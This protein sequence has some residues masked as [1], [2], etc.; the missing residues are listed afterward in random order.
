MHS[1]YYPQCPY[2]FYILP[3]EILGNV[4]EQFLGSVITISGAH[5]ADVVPKPEVKKAGGVYYTPA[6]IVDYI[7]KNTVG[8]LIEGKTPRQIAN[9][10]ILDPACGSGSFLLGAYTYLLNYLRDWY[11]DNDP[12]KHTKK[13]YQG[14]GAQWYLTN[15]EKKRILLNNIF[16]VDIDSQAVEVTKLSLLLKVLEG[17]D[18]QTL[19]NQYR[20]FHER[21]LPDLGNNIKCGN[22]LIGPDFFENNPPNSIDPEEYRR[23]NPFDYKEEFPHIFK[24]K[25]PGFNA[26]IGNPPYRKERDSK[27][28]ISELRQSSYGKKYYMGKMDFWY[29]FLHRAMDLTKANGYI[30][31]IVPSYWLKSTG[32]SKLI[33][34]IKSECSFLDVVDIGKN[35]VF[36]NVGGQH[37]TFVLAKNTSHQQL[38]YQRYAS[39]GLTPFEIS[40]VLFEKSQ[41]H[42]SLLTLDNSKIYTSDNKIDFERSLHTSLLQKFA[43]SSFFLEGQDKIFLVSQGIV[44]APDIV[45]SAMAKKANKPDLAGCGVFVLSPEEF[46]SYEFNKREK[47]FLK[48]YLRAADVRRYYHQFTGYYVFYIGSVENRHIASNRKLYPNIIRHLNQYKKFITSSNAPYGIHRTRKSFYFTSEKL[49]CP[50]MFDKPCFTYC[51][52]ESYVNFAFNVVVPN[53]PLYSLKYL[54]A[55]LNSSLGAFWFNINGKK[56]GVN[57]DVGVAVMRRFPVHSVDFSNPTEKAKHDKMVKLVD[58]MLDLHKRLADAKVPAEKT[59][60]QRQINTTDKQIDK[61]TYELYDLTDEE[62]KIAEETM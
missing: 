16:G 20:L 32:S 7:V 11:V 26:V 41:A 24:T 23:I 55:V 12:Q 51:P 43:S 42:S 36:E 25:N 14:K 40:Q 37:M 10:K 56:R 18:S 44:E 17:E 2:E 4:Y 29:F 46:A 1:L 6:Y 47:K 27:K 34:H 53:A 52:E 35:R 61:L 3:P 62:I 58:R 39:K 19:E 9:I 38:S 57:N 13:I 8:K 50:N 33:K 49:L 54:L 45:S 15:A 28:L 30:S 48:P 5:R 21:A 22:S 60:I 59:R 31:F